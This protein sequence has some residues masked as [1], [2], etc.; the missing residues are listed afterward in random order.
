MTAVLVAVTKICSERQ[1]LVGCLKSLLKQV[2]TKQEREVRL[3]VKKGVSFSMADVFIQRRW[4]GHSPLKRAPGDCLRAQTWNHNSRCK[5]PA[6]AQVLKTLATAKRCQG[7]DSP[8]ATFTRQQLRNPHSAIPLFVSVQVGIYAALEPCKK[9]GAWKESSSEQPRQPCSPQ[10][11]DVRYG[12]TQGV[13]LYT[14]C[15]PFSKGG[16]GEG[17]GA[18]AALC[19]AVQAGCDHSVWRNHVIHGER[20]VQG[21]ARGHKRELS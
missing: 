12:Q 8:L 11:V 2:P 20:L 17:W 6:S 16:W 18:S 7:R 15:H 13:P 9:I 21:A 3:E 4:R 10:R 5:S 19:S 14:Q 1:A